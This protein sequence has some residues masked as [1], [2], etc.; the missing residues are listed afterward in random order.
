MRERPLWARTMTD[1]QLFRWE[2]HR[3]GHLWTLLGVTTDLA[4]D[5]DWIRATLGGRSVFV[6]RFGEVLRGF[7]NVCAH[8]SF[9]LRTADRGHGPVRCGFH[10]WQYD[11]EGTAM[12]IPKCK[13]MFGVTPKELGAKL[14]PLEVGI[15]GRLVFG[16]FP[17]AGEETL[18]HYL[19]DGFP[20]LEASTDV[21][22]F[23][24][25]LLLSFA[26]NWKLGFHI[27]LDDYHLVAVHP[28]T[29]GRRGYLSPDNVQ[30]HRFGRHSA[31][32][33]GAGA[34]EGALDEMVAACQAESY[35]PTAYRIFQFFPNLIVSHL[36]AAGRWNVLIQQYVPLAVDRTELRTWYFAAPFPEPK[37]TLRRRLAR[38]VAAPFLPI[39]VPYYVRKICREDNRICERMQ[40]VAAQIDGPPVL[41]RHEERIAWFQQTYEECVGPEPAR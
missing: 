15:C 9:P 34:G 13:E 36:E 1:P 40:E 38:L 5:G 41:G 7:E 23:P 6:Q 27:S 3:L 19:G 33:F 28:D 35:Q 25:P 16:R 12:G 10:H 39:A 11:Q 37:R 24:R 4:R 22:K 32:F 14:T 8:R 30:Y 26:A 31:Y 21:G 17:G 18:E 29:F 2:Q 20:V